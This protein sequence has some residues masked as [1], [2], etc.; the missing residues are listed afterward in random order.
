MN[1]D[2]ENRLPSNINITFPKIPSDLLVVELSAKGI[3][4]SS[5]SACKSS[6]KNG[7][8]V[9]D[10][11]YSAKVGPSQKAQGPTF[12]RE[13]G[14]VRFSFGAKTTKSDI[15]YVIKA[16]SDILKKIKKWYN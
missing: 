3:M 14:G 15:D 16:L 10:A 7:S 11:L 5:K 8:Y 4:T 9:I 6:S 1:G 12:A 13:I 2:L